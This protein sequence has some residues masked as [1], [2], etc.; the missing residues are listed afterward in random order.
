LK[1]ESAA[2]SDLFISLLGE[3]DS[4][5]IKQNEALKKENYGELNRLYEQMTILLNKINSDTQDTT[6]NT[7]QLSNLE[8]L[9]TEIK[10]RHKENEQ[11]ILEKMS[12]IKS[13]LSN[14]KAKSKINKGYSTS[15][16]FNKGIID[17]RK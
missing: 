16:K 17:L 2:G 5:I 13:R 8:K 9:T 12:M 6:I 15:G 3:I 4:I 14:L 1:S 7:E 10:T 11:Y